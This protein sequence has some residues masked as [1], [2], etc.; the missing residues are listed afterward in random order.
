MPSLLAI[1]PTRKTLERKGSRTLWVVSGLQNE[2]VKRYSMTLVHNSQ[3]CSLVAYLLDG[4]SLPSAAA[5]RLTPPSPSKEGFPS[6]TSDIS[7][8]Q[9]TKKPPKLSFSAMEHIKT[10][11]EALAVELGTDLHVLIPTILE[12]FG[13]SYSD[14]SL[15]HH[16]HN[17]S[18]VS[19]L[20]EAD[21]CH[22]VESTPSQSSGLKNVPGSG[23]NGPAEGFA[24][25][26]IGSAVTLPL[27]ARCVRVYPFVKLAYHLTSC[28]KSANPVAFHDVDNVPAMNS[29]IASAQI[30]M[31][32]LPAPSMNTNIIDM[33]W[34]RF[35]S[36]TADNLSGVANTN[37]RSSDRAGPSAITS[38]TQS[39]YVSRFSPCEGISN[40]HDSEDM[41]SLRF[42]S[43]ASENRF[44]RVDFDPSYAGHA[45]VT[46]TSNFKSNAQITYDSLSSLPCEGITNPYQHGLQNMDFNSGA[47]ED[48]FNPADLDTRV[49]G[50]VEYAATTSDSQ[51]MYDSQ[52]LPPYEGTTN[53]DQRSLQYIEWLRLHNPNN[54]GLHHTTYSGHDPASSFDSHAASGQ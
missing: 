15:H 37:Q 47:G 51:L 42:N 22:Y 20:N 28:N 24:S 3:R 4:D 14:G 50:Y 2:G 54:V 45:S 33:G 48:I 46:S 32:S 44:G 41:K 49:P 7:S 38:D 17:D 40:Q 1:E 29:T 19:T 31:A 6:I 30:G 27:L 53:L 11:V 16:S 18:Y 10:A 9:S 21:H 34:L 8:S 5:L 35:N 25:Q 36:K 13:E 39:T 52:Y 12:L 26:S 23:Q 43:G